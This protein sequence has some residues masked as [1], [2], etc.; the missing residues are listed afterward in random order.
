M[1]RNFTL[2]PTKDRPPKF[3]ENVYAVAGGMSIASKARADCVQEEQVCEAVNMMF[4][5][6]DL[7]LENANDLKRY[8]GIVHAS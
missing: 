1:N 3:N 8:H 2:A 7:K 4:K 6:N 5:D